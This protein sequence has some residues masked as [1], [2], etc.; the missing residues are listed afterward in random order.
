M[1]ANGSP[2]TNAVCEWLIQVFRVLDRVSDG[3]GRPHSVK[4][5]RGVRQRGPRMGTP[6][7]AD[8]EF[9]G[10]LATLWKRHRVTNMDRIAKIEATTA[11]ILSSNADPT[12]IS[13]ATDVAHQ[14]AGSLGTFGFDAGSKAALETEKLLREQ[15]ID[16]RRLATAVSKLRSSVEGSE[17]RDPDVAH[18]QPTSSAADGPVV[19]IVSVDEKLIAKLEVEAASAGFVVRTHADPFSLDV[20]AGVEP[21]ALILDV[22]GPWPEEELCGKVMQLATAVPVFVLAQLDDLDTRVRFS[23]SGAAGVIPRFQDPQQTVAFVKEELK[24]EEPLDSSI[25]MLT[26]DERLADTL[27]R[28]VTGTGCRASVHSSPAEFWEALE[29]ESAD[30][31]VIAFDNGRFHGSEMCRVI[32]TDPRWC[33]MPVVVIGNNRIDDIERCIVTGV[34]DYLSSQVSAR[35]LGI[36]LLNHLRSVRSVQR[37]TNIDPLSGTENQASAHRSLDR[38]L[39]SARSQDEPAT[40]ALLSVDQLAQIRATHGTAMADTVIRQLGSVL[41]ETFGP[42]DLVGRWNED[43]YVVGIAG[44][45]SED[46]RNRLSAVTAAFAANQFPTT[47]GLASYTVSVGAAST[48]TDGTSISSLLSLSEAALGRASESRRSV[49]TASE[50][51]TPTARNTVDIVIVEDDDSVADVVEHVATLRGYSFV[52]FSDGAEAANAL[53]GGIVRGR[54]ILLDVGLPSLD[55]FGVLRTLGAQGVIGD[56]RVIMLTA[57][58]SETEMLRALGLGATEHISKPFSIQVLLGRLAQSLGRAA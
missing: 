4:S 26:A 5:D 21:A 48:P 13:E 40:V 19:A 55:G 25:V 15:P 38:L 12:S 37:R 43:E 6:Q 2:Y 41:K 17:V 23:R 51:V 42:P 3:I 32:R 30:L 16:G 39:Q 44:V 9:G 18:E 11:K 50:R 56:A 58:S 28:A 34:D 35:Q 24:R 31:A 52:R 33:R 22:Q 7:T 57:R 20:S 45:S 46:A 1:D 10:M 54:V 27:R 14:L 36:R 29:S 53:G 49:V 8:A 47:T